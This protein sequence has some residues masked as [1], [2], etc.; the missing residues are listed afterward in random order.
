MHPNTQGG[1]MKEKIKKYHTIRSI[2]GEAI[3]KE[4]WLSRGH[5]TINTARHAFLVVLIWLTLFSVG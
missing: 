3:M 4:K 5:H 2:G 1:E